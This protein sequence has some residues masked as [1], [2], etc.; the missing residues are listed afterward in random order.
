MRCLRLAIL[1]V[2]LCGL[3]VVAPRVASAQSVEAEAGK[4]LYQAGKK[5]FERRRY[6]QAAEKFEKALTVAFGGQTARADKGL[7]NMLGRS[8]AELGRCVEAVPILVA[9]E[10]PDAPKPFATARTNAEITCRRELAGLAV[11]EGR[12]TD[13]MPHLKAL[14]KHMKGSQQR[15]LAD[16]VDGCQEKLTEFDTSTPDRKAAYQLFVAAREQRDKWRL[17]RAADLYGK[18]LAVVDEPLIRVEF[19]E[20]LFQRNDCVGVVDALASVPSEH[21]TEALRIGYDRCREEVAES[22]PLPDPMGS[23]RA[24]VEPADSGSGM[25][26]GGWISL[27]AGVGLGAVAGGFVSMQLDEAAKYNAEYQKSQSDAPSGLTVAEKENWVLEMNEVA[28]AAYDTSIQNST[29]AFVT[30]G[31]GVAALGTGIVLLLLASGEDDPDA[32][33]VQVTPIISPTSM[34]LSVRF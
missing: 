21:V 11:A 16:A 28:R 1:F 7:L 25:A 10:T 14:A 32:T 29:V 31:I 3:V 2:S 13:A 20:V 8:Y 4:M 5:A 19:A 18:A 23:A 24:P 17:E 15:W 12:C 22:S 6:A 9:A 34:G 30:G 27:A 26:I 33:S